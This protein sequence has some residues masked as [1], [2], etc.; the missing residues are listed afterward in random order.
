VLGTTRHDRAADVLLEVLHGVER[1][2]ELRRQAARAVARSRRGAGEL[3]RLARADELP[4][5][6]RAA[7]AFELN[8]APWSEVRE[9]AAEL[10]PLPAAR[11]ERPLPSIADLLEMK[12]DAGRGRE[13]F[14]RPDTCSNCHVARGEGKQVGPELSEIGSKLS[15][16]A[17]LESILFPSAGISHGYESW[18]VTTKSGEVLTGLITSDTPGEVSVKAGDAIV[19]TVKTSEVLSRS[20]Q[21]T[22]LMPADLQKLMTAQELADV[23]AYLEALRKE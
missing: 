16:E 23:V 2:P 17:L 11:D 20:M 5:D 3:L 8:R 22:S 1:P 6:L 15:R 19:R 21:A 9:P 12:G 10:F 7:A 18:I 13:V 14:N 4:E